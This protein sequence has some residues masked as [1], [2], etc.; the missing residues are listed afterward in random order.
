VRRS[1]S[2]AK[3]DLALL[4]ATRLNDEKIKRGAESL[5]AGRGL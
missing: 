5:V 4:D 2:P 1:D 3:Q